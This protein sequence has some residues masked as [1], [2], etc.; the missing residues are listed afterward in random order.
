MENNS[1]K[2]RIMNRILLIV[3][4]VVLSIAFSFGLK[5]YID[6]KGVR[7]NEEE[8]LGAPFYCKA[9][10]Y[11]NQGE[12]Q[13]CPAG[14]YCRGGLYSNAYKTPC[15]SG[16]T[17]NSG[18]VSS[19]DCYCPSGKYME[20]GIC[21][22]CPKGYK[23]D[24]SNKTACTG[25]T[26]Q[27]ETG[28][29]TCKSCSYNAV[30]ANNSGGNTACTECSPGQYKGTN[31]TCTACPV[32]YYCNGNSSFKCDA[33]YTT[34][35]TGAS[36]KEQCV[37]ESSDNNCK[38]TGISKT[39]NYKSVGDSYNVIVTVSGTGCNGK[40]LSVSA[41]NAS[42]NVSSIT[43]KNAGD[44]TF[45][46]TV[47]NSCATSKTTASLGT[48]KMSVSVSTKPKWTGPHDYEVQVS[49]GLTT[50]KSSADNSGEDVYYSEKGS[51]S[52]D[53][54]KQCYKKRYTRPGSCSNISNPSNPDY[55]CFIDENGEYKWDTKK[56]GYTLV[57][58]I[59]EEDDCKKP[60]IVDVSICEEKEIVPK[61]EIKNATCN[62][63]ISFSDDV[64]KSCSFETSENDFYKI[65][66]KENLGVN[67]NPSTTSS[68]RLGLGFSYDISINTE[69]DCIGEFDA[70]GFKK[71]YNN[72]K[73]NIENAT[74]D[75]DK[76]TNENKLND[77]KEILYNYNNWESNYNLGDITAKLKD[78]QT[79][80]NIN[81]IEKD[82]DIN[83]GTKT[84]KSDNNLGITGLTDPI[85]FEYAETLTKT[86]TLPTAYYNANKIVYNA[87]DGC[88][89]LS[90]QYYISDNRKYI[91]TDYRYTINVNGLGYN[92]SWNVKTND[93]SLKV[94]EDPIIYRPIEVS[95]PFLESVDSNRQTG[96][97]WKNGLFDFTNIIKEDIW[98]KDSLYVFNITN[99]NVK[100]IRKNNSELGAN[101][102]LGTDCKLI[103]SS[104]RYYCEF[105]RNDMYFHYHYIHTDNVR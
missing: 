18:S 100:S 81:F 57:E 58:G 25:N 36:S 49:S 54:S 75:A 94:V 62:G 34:E 2:K 74:S 102:Y 1:N 22:I 90:N 26:Y 23:C 38:I 63:N 3:I 101:A 35:S 14:N 17:S 56:D 66:C 92:K 55:A 44:Y 12:C 67:L 72:V 28:K 77:L 29:S 9:G 79:T 51:C 8:P 59:D 91:D 30:S 69:R 47:N 11:A 60:E 87:C 99:Q 103:T 42:V 39:S 61:E 40:V 24:G 6:Y 41:S 80:N 16:K 105:L 7:I 85:D 93:C 98:T 21:T 89:K 78:E 86:F 4:C 83:R 27:N 33:G 19:S 43:L 104:N 15:S 46:V 68:I 31:S 70:G 73:K 82:N 76:R 20:N 97:N 96:R 45:K 5:T 37:K 84:K 88:I 32:G 65:T 13:Y 64:T 53:S 48:S 10:T 71:A 52:F 95:D 50:S